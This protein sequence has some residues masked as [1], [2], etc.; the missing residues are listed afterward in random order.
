[1]PDPSYNFKCKYLINA[2]RNFIN[3][4]NSFIM[5]EIE[6]YGFDGDIFII[7]QLH[8]KY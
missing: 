6:T 7:T 4:S 1:M 5:L 2:D 3:N 8:G